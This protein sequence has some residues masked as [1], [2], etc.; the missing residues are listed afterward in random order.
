MAKKK[1]EIEDSNLISK[2]MFMILGI[3]YFVLGIDVLFNFTEK[4]D[5]IIG[6][7]V[8]T[9]GIIFLLASGFISAVKK[10]NTVSLFGAIKIKLGW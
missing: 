2:L 4:L 9:L 6:I 1:I 3:I 10:D 5:I 8:I 7:Q